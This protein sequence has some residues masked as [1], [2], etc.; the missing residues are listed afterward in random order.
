MHFCRCYQVRMDNL[1]LNWIVRSVLSISLA[2][3]TYAQKFQWQALFRFHKMQGIFWLIELLLL[4]PKEGL[5]CMKL[6][7]YA[8]LYITE[9]LVNL[10]P[11]CSV[12]QICVFSQYKDFTVG[13]RSHSA[14]S[15][16]AVAGWLTFGII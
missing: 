11:L 4:V 9:T 12:L 13:S 6:V 15:W 8:D 7:N 1:G 14:L 3:V 10:F 2:I 5:C 16:W